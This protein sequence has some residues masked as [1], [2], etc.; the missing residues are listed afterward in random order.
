MKIDDPGRHLSDARLNLLETGD[1][2]DLAQDTS[3]TVGYFH[4]FNRNMCS[5]ED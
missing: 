5:S 4:T 1:W 2:F 3:D